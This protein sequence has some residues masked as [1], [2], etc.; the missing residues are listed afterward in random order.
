[1]TK[2]LKGIVKTAI[3]QKT[4]IIVVEHVNIHPK[5]K[6]RLKINKSYQVHTDIKVKKGDVVE[7]ESTRPISKLK[8]FK[9]TKIIK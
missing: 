2:K 3:A 6:K 7:I 4:A 1:M 5:Y 9:I 8:H